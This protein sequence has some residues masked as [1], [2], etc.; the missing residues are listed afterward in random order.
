MRHVSCE[1]WRISYRSNCFSLE[2]AL[3]YDVTAEERAAAVDPEKGPDPDQLQ[4]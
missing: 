1:L 4:V 2:R 3:G